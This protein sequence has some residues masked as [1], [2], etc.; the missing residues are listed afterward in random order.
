[1]TPEAMHKQITEFLERYSHGPDI[2]FIVPESTSFGHKRAQE[3]LEAFLNIVD[4]IIDSQ[5]TLNLQEYALISFTVEQNVM[6][7]TDKDGK[8]YEFSFQSLFQQLEMEANKSC[9]DTHQDYYQFGRFSQTVKN[10]DNLIHE[11]IKDS[12]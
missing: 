10:Y 2:E 12:L 1:M 9:T 6:R 3:A 11:I 8:V 7:A 5:Q 4:I